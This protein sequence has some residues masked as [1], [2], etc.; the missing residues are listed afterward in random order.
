MFKSLDARTGM[1]PTCVE[2]TGVDESNPSSLLKIAAD[3]HDAGDHAE[4][5]DALGR[6]LG[7]MNPVEIGIETALLMPVYLQRAGQSD[8]AWR[9]FER[10]LNASL[11]VYETDPATAA[12]EFCHIHNRMRTVSLREGNPPDAVRNGVFSYMWLFMA[13]HHQDRFEEMDT[14]TSEGNISALL[15]KLLGDTDLA[16]AHSDLTEI[17]HRHALTAPEIDFG[18][19][20]REIRETI[21]DLAVSEPS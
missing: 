4:A 7:T 11:M 13:L 18:E 6:A 16:S 21:A 14:K 10:L 2:A 1:C 19:L 5:V 3:R 15:R 20:D 8:E 12:V 17:V 9:E